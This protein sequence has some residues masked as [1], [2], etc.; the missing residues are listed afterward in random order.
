MLL[1]A[2]LA[3]PDVLALVTRR[4]VPVRVSGNPAVYT[5]D[6]GR[7]GASDP[8]AELGTSI[9]DEKATAL[10]VSDG[11]R[12]VASLTNIGTFDRDLVLRFLQGAL[13]RVGGLPPGGDAWSLLADGRPDDAR[14]L[15]AR[16]GGREGEYGLVRAASLRGDHEAALRQALPLARADGPFRDEAEAEAGRA[17][18]RLGRP[19]G[20][21]AAAPRG[22]P[23]A[24]RRGRRRTS[25]AAPA[26]GRPA[27]SGP[28][29]LAGRGRPVPGHPDGR[30]RPGPPG[31]ARGPG[32]VREPD[33]PRPRAGLAAR[34]Q[35][36]TEVDRSGEEERTRPDG[37]RLPAR[38]A[39]PGRHLVVGLAGG[40]VP[41]RHHGDRRPVAAP[42]EH[43]ARRR[44]RRAGPGGLGAGDRLA[45]PGDRP[46]R[47][48]AD[49][50]VRGGLSPGLLPRP[51]GD[52][53]LD[54][55]R[56]P[57]GDP[58]PAGRPV[59]HRRLE[60]RLRVRGELAQESRPEDLP[61]ADAQHEHRAWR[62][63]RWPGRGG[64]ASTSMRRPSRKARRP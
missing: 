3:D 10:V 47:P 45:E 37:D 50:L 46:R 1:A 28:R 49:G 19:V 36:S 55:G 35:G 9:R 42:L 34:D 54:Q 48:V 5:M 2:V 30:P 16:M 26:P 7:P 59:P 25:S 61:R 39:G 27:G 17:L 18:L 44:P 43:P 63:S 21:G 32:H 52:G 53:G 15:F 11:E 6:A 40:E 57:G 23:R 22:R 14:A 38:R 4:F 62:C 20:G 24:G 13:A 12:R 56:H 51:G 8:L 29:R 64:E 41:G 31:L 60:L 58:P 33:R